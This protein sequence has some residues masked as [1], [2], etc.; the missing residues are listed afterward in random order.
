MNHRIWQFGMPAVAA[1]AALALTHRQWP[2]FQHIPFLPGFAAAVLSSACAGITA[3][4]LAVAFTLFGYVLF[5]LPLIQPGVLLG[6]TAIAGAFAW[7]VARLD[8]V[9]AAFRASEARLMLIVNSLPVVIFAIDQEGRFTLA[10]G[11]G[12]EMAERESS[13]LMGRSVFELYRDVPELLE[14]IERARQGESV[15]ETVTVR[16]TVY[17][18]WL[19][20]TRERQDEVN[21]VVGIALNITTRVRLEQ[22]YRHAQKMESVGQMAAG[23]AHDF[24]NLITAIGGYSEMTMESFARDDRRREDL[25][26]VCK[27]AERATILTKQIL[28][29]SR[30]QLLHPRVL[31]VN[32]LVG[33]VQVLLRRAIS[34]KIAVALDLDPVL[35][36][37]KVDPTQ[38]EQVL[39]NLAMNAR[40]AMPGG[41]KLRFVTR[42]VTI[43]PQQPSSR[44]FP[45]P[46]GRYVCIQVSDTGTGMTP[47]VQ[48][49]IF[50]PFFTTK[51]RGKGTGL[52]L[53][54]TYGI[55][56][57]SGG[58]IWVESTPGQGTTF[59]IYL[60]AVREA[61]A[62]VEETAPSTTVEG[63]SETILLAEDDGGVRR[64]AQSVLTAS[65]YTVLEARDGQEA[66]ALA[67][68]YRGTINLLI[69]DVVMPGIGGARL[70]AQ[71]VARHP[72]LRALYTSGYASDVT[73]REG[74]AGDVP[75][76]PKP[77]LPLDLL[78]K[79]R[80]VLDAA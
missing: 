3:G 63:G 19:R 21:G 4:I 68:G 35:E 48:Q 44:L 56:K 23:I 28:A 15:S 76:L 30:K 46:P 9:N 27:A 11:K 67:D 13:Q 57:Q 8:V 10:E 50:E 62:G 60:P 51:E 78:R 64:L 5:P 80:Q 49:H 72:G 71:L 20:P 58:F 54:T 18:L 24:N 32:L 39:V 34:E 75:F 43:Q 73:F 55:V 52:G 66:I 31:D 29:F 59:E 17:E 22:H 74:V 7:L 37:V 42:T 41:G 16:A 45:M 33:Q 47:E 70:A 65:G 69:S 53:A 36:P 1:A 26:E 14:T 61:I 12:L 79:V 40:D 25:R 77:F 6:F 2:V 38:L